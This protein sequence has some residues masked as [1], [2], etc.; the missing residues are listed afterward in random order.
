MAVEDT[1]G[2]IETSDT[3][4]TVSLGF[5]ANP[6]SST[7]T[8][9]NSGGSGPVSVSG[10][11]ASFTCSLNKAATGY[12]LSATSNPAHGTATSNSFNIVAASA[13][14]L[15]FSTEPPASTAA[16]STFSTSVTIED[17]YGNKVTSDSSTVTIALYTN[18]CGGTLGGTTSKA[19]SSGVASFSGLQITK[20]CSGYQLSGTDVSDG[21]MLATSSPFAIT[22]AGASKLVFTTEPPASTP[23]TS[24]FA[25]ALTIEDTYGNTV[26]S[27]THTVALSLSTNPCSGTLSGTTSKAASSGVANFSGLQITKVCTGYKLSATDA[28]DSLTVTSSAFAITAA[29]ANAISVV[30]GNNQSATQGAAF[31]APLVVEVTTN[32]TTRCRGPRSP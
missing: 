9:T 30:S 11:V 31:S 26:T 22:A 14:Q 7:L 4:T 29:S 23:S 12:S 5:S 1:Y 15:V 18:P 25:V 2:N 6:G 27:D 19:A 8:C 24:T 20:A 16:S 10:G 17:L 3:T 32:T 28:S 21:P 13:S